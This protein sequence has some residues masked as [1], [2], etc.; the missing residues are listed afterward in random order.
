MVLEPEQVEA[1]NRLRVNL[2]QVV[3]ALGTVKQDLEQSA[4]LPKWYL[5]RPIPLPP[6]S[7]IL[8]WGQH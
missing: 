5:F 3:A 8:L 2:V 4:P 7:A 1:L 6:F